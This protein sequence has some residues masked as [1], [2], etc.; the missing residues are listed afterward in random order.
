MDIREI[1]FTLFSMN[2]PLF[3]LSA[4]LVLASDPSGRAKKILWNI[5]AHVG[6]FFW[7]YL[8]MFGALYDVFGED[9]VIWAIVWLISVATAYKMGKDHRERR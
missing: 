6:V 2:L 3:F 1:F 4:I 5:V 9:N 8:D 7:F